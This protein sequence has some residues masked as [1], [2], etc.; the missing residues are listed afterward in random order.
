MLFL[1]APVVY[2]LFLSLSRFV[3][4]RHVLPVTLAAYAMTGFAI[5]ELATL[6][7]RADLRWLAVAALSAILLATS[8][9]PARAMYHELKNET[10]LQ[11]RAWIQKNLPPSSVI[12]QDRPAHLNVAAPEFLA[13][14]G[15]V[16]QA[17]VTPR[18]LFVTDLGSLAELRAQ[19]VTHIVTCDEAYARIFSQ[20]VIDA[21]E[22]EQYHIRRARYEEIFSSARLIFEAKPMRPVGGSTSPVVRV[23]AIADS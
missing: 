17:V 16:T 8:I 22:R 15:K 19:G 20:H 11:L 7:R 6:L 14:Y 23:Y 10:R 13:T 12:A 9:V 2:L 21:A 4:D 3:L 18:D 5:T 1:P